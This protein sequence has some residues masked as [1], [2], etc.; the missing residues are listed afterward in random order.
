MS[1]EKKTIILSLGPLH[2]FWTTGVYYLYE[3]SQTYNVILIAWDSY[4]RDAEFQQVIAKLAVKEIIYIP[5]GGSLRRSWFL[6]KAF[7]KLAT[8]HKISLVFQH[9]YVYEDNLY[10][11]HWILKNQPACKFIRYQNGMA[12]LK[13]Y[14]EDFEA[15]KLF[16]INAIASKY[17]LPLFLAKRFY[18]CKR[19]LLYLANYRIFPFLFA[20]AVFHPEINVYTGK[21]AKLNQKQKVAQC[22]YR[23]FY[24]KEELQVCKSRM[25]VA[26]NKCILVR[27]PLETVGEKCNLLIYGQSSSKEEKLIL[28]LPSGGTLD[29]LFSSG[30]SA[31]HAVGKIV[32]K[33]SQVIMILRKHYPGSHIMLKLHSIFATSRIHL[34]FQ[35]CLSR[36]HPVLEIA[37][38]KSNAQKL[39]IRSKVVVSEASTVLWWAVFLTGKRAIS[40]DIFGYKGGD[41][42]RYHSGVRYCNNLSELKETLMRQT[43]S[44]HERPYPTVTQFLSA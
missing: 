3:L 35:E 43:E 15:R 17:R 19:W 11:Q 9:A 18:F 30:A 8:R 39:I 31:D 4:E 25:E 36:A 37:D 7:R 13:Y 22:D 41:E 23:L 42:M 29:I 32:D 34:N 24:T 27:H 21:L 16:G 2:L 5:V 10:L 40:L 20:A 28:I 14:D 12:I 1:E 26:A 33:W 44:N 6:A 38:P